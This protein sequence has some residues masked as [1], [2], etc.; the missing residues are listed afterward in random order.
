MT[1]Q[2]RRGELTPVVSIIRDPRVLLLQQ[3]QETRRR[4][5]AERER[6]A[7]Q[8]QESE[9]ERERLRRELETLRRRFP[10]GA[11]GSRPQA[12]RLQGRQGPPREPGSY[13]G[14]GGPIGALP[15]GQ[16]QLDLGQFRKSLQRK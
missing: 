11:N 8:L 4:A 2:K 13:E 15:R 6:L 9:A 3:E 14:G 16:L 7:L 12:S 1:H 5:E 10:D